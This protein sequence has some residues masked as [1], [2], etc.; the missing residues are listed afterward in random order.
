MKENTSLL[1]HG[2]SDQH[3]EF[4]YD[5]AQKELGSRSRTKAIIALIDEKMGKEP[6]KIDNIA[7]PTTATNGKKKRLQISLREAEYNL[8]DEFTKNN[9]TSIQFYV[10]SLILKDLYNRDRLVG[11]EIEVLRKSN[12]E[13]YKIGVNVNQ[14]AKA[15]NMGKQANLPINH[16]CQQ[17][18][19]HI[20]KVE[21]L[22]RDS[23]EKY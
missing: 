17:I 9:D 18:T 22:L 1:V 14:I 3:K 11:N 23:I 13:L 20:E 21:K 10:V 19:K 6:K 7:P 8:L 2:L 5:Y 12:Y 4:L 15:L 16:L